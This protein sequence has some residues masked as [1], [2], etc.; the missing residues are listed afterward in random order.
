MDDDRLGLEGAQPATRSPD[1]AGIVI[2]LTGD[3]GADAV[4]D[5][6]PTVVTRRP[7][8]ALLVGAVAASACAVALVAWAL[9]RPSEPTTTTTAVP[10]STA[11]S[12][13]V[14]ST[15]APTTTTVPRSAG[16]APPQPTAVIAPPLVEE[17][18]AS[19]AQGA[20]G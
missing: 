7:R 2:D 1:D 13:A 18:P 3:L 20:S 12:G 19:G 6:V 14:S 17:R 10:S 16:T 15:A 11:S 8:R 4:A 9:G 5:P